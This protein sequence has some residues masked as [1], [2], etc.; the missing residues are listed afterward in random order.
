[1]NQSATDRVP[2]RIYALLTAYFLSALAAVGQI[3][4]LGKQV[5]DMTGRELDLG[6]IG[7]AEFTPA[8]LAAP[9]A[10]A[11]ADRMDRRR[12][13]AAALAAEAVVSLGLF[14]Y[15]RSDPTSVL[16]IFGLVLVFGALKTFTGAA[17]RPLPVD[18]A[19]PALFPRVVA[20]ENVAFQAGLIVGPVLF[21]FL[22]VVDEAAPYLAAA[23]ALALGS[24][25]VVL[26]PT[27]PVRRL[28]TT[29]IRQSLAD[30]ADGLRFVRR[31]PVLAGAITLDLFA[32]LFGGAVALLPAIAEDRLGVG[33]VGLGW[34]RAAVGIG[35]GCAAVTMVVRPLSR[36]I[37]PILLTAV[38][39]FGLGT[40]VLGLSRNYVLAFV[41]IMVLSGAD[42]I[43]MFIR[44]TLTPL[45]TPE[46]M[47][48]RVLALENV[49]VGASNELGAFESGV[50]AALLGLTGAVVF[51]GVGALV[52]VAVWAVK[53]PALR[54]V[55]R[56]DEVRTGD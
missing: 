7:L 1:M 28:H 27:T 17:G 47:R 30:A 25:V 45:A 23:V 24:L 4:I 52:V 46:H 15:A 54:D 55:D 11:L 56:F 42:A 31:R 9:V 10:G 44:T 49:F 51:G 21:G 19:P 13:F 6:F 37:G 3:T 38:G 35:A 48:G 20:M 14:G 12:L 43:S 41:A 53:F 8:L 29:G 18:M 34:L 50:T 32:M 16:P 26:I 2:L 33:A 39:V 22:F 40:I 5:Y 36:R